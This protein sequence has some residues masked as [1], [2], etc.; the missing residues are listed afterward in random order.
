M[1]SF[2]TLEEVANIHDEMAKETS[3]NI[4]LYHG[5]FHFN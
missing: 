3:H 5:I 1:Q 2:M 4:S